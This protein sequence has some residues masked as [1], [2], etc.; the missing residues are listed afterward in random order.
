[1][2]QS[3]DELLDT[4]RRLE[5]NPATAHFM[6]RAPKGRKASPQ[7]RLLKHVLRGAEA[8]QQA[9]ESADSGHDEAAQALTKAPEKR[10]EMVSEV[11]PEIEAAS[12]PR[13][14]MSTKE[15][16]QYIG[17]CPATLYR[18]IN[19][20]GFPR[21]RKLGHL[22]RWLRDEIDAHLMALPVMVIPKIDWI[23][24]KKPKK[25]SNKK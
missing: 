5:R 8:A 18:L 24:G 23:D 1:M 21:P 11:A 12:E 25:N 3:R 2:V 17:I 15:V 22:S 20:Q 13:R 10:Q 6:V 9:A 4:L 16:T 14:W 7:E 19:E